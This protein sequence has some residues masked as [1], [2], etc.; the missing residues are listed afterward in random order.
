MPPESV[1][2]YHISRRGE[3]FFFQKKFRKIL[4]R[5]VGKG[6]QMFHEKRRKILFRTVIKGTVR[7]TGTAEKG[8]LTVWGEHKYFLLSAIKGECQENPLKRV[9]LQKFDNDNHRNHAH[10]SKDCGNKAAGGFSAALGV[11]FGA[12]SFGVNGVESLLAC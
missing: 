9:L 1:Y 3:S 11:E 12:V 4:L 2:F 6:A 7:I 5:T 10:Q 8:G